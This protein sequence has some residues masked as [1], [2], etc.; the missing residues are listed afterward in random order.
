MSF[1]KSTALSVFANLKYSREEREQKFRDAAA[2][3]VNAVNDIVLHHAGVLLEELENFDED[4]WIL[5]DEC[6]S[7]ILILRDLGLER[8]NDLGKSEVCMKETGEIWMLIHLDGV[9]GD[10]F[11]PMFL[12]GSEHTVIERLAVGVDEAVEKLGLAGLR[13]YFNGSDILKK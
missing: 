2:A 3:M 6:G 9:F 13:L 11:E 7:A 10:D 12:R 4:N 5:G 1:L 8:I